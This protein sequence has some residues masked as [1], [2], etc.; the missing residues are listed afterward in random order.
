MPSLVILLLST[1]YNV[2]VTALSNRYHSCTS[3]LHSMVVF[4]YPWWAECELE[5]LDW[6][7]EKNPTKLFAHWCV[8]IYWWWKS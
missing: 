8:S 1:R 6:N 3:I 2:F 5:N 4:L 7:R